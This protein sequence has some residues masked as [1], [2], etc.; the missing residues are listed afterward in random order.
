MSVWLFFDRSRAKSYALLRQIRIFTAY[1]LSHN[2][3]CAVRWVS[4]ELNSTDEPSRLDSN[5]DSKTLVHAIPAVFKS[6]EG[7]IPSSSTGEKEDSRP[8]EISPLA[9]LRV[10]LF[11]G[12]E[13]SFTQ[14]VVCGE[15]FG[16][17]E[18]PWY[19]QL[20]GCYTGH[21]APFEEAPKRVFNGLHQLH[22]ERQEEEVKGIRSTS[23]QEVQ[24]FSEADNGAWQHD[25][26]GGTCYQ[27]SDSTPV[28]YAVEG[29]H[30][31]CALPW[32]KPGRSDGGGQGLA[33]PHKHTFHG[34]SA[35]LPCRSPFSRLPPHL[36]TVREEW[37][38]QAAPLLACHQ[39]VSEVDSRKESQ[40]YPLGSMGSLC[41]GDEEK[42][43][44]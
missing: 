21:S 19:I 29:V 8:Q 37:T 16:D 2:I 32:G 41:R 22:T 3:S 30:G 10:E 31:L 6:P 39:G 17:P 1:C 9:P 24:I 23:G 13:D 15:G 34:R 11:E 5:E 42:R 28:S 7:A 43:I 12:R 36:P 25:F 27:A 38:P 20:D 44:P 14:K 33:R 4:S 35:E 26:V 18:D 40:S